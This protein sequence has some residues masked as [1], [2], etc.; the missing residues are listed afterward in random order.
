LTP[1]DEK[2]AGMRGWRSHPTLVVIG[3][4]ALTTIT[5]FPVTLSSTPLGI[6]TGPGNEVWFTEN[7]GNSVGA[8][9]A[10]SALT[11]IALLT[12]GSRPTDITSGPDGNL[13]FTAATTHRVVRFAP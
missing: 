1:D 11:E 4:G 3:S 9:T 2:I 5:E 13:W 10:S 7:S 12:P 8:I 6:T